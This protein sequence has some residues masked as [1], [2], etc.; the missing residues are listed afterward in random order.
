MSY[1]STPRPVRPWATALRTSLCGLALLCLAGPALGQDDDGSALDGPE[2]AFL[3]GLR[4]RGMADF[5]LLEIDRLAAAE[6][7]PAELVAALPFERALTLLSLARNPSAAGNARARLDEA[8]ALLE[9]FAQGNPNSPLAGDAQFL[10]AEILQQAAADLLESDDPVALPEETKTQAR[11]LLQDAERVYGDARTALEKTIRDIG[12]EQRDEAAAARRRAAQG[13]LIRARVEAARVIFRRAE[14]YAVGTPDRTR[15]LDEADAPLE[16]LRK[17]SRISI[18]SLPGRILQAQIRTARVPEEPAA[19]EALSGGAKDAAVQN[20]TVAATILK[21]VLDQQPPDGASNAVRDAVEA[22]RGTAQRL[23]LSVLN[24]PLKADYQTV[25]TQATQWLDGDRARLGTDSGAGVLFERGIAQ[26]RGAPE[27]EGRD[28]TRALR[29]ALADFQT[30]A[31]RSQAISGVAKEAAARVR[32]SLG[33]DREEPRTFVEAFD[34]A[35]DQLRQLKE[36][37]DAVKAA[38]TP[39]DK[40]AAQEDLDA[41]LAETSRLLNLANEL[42]DGNTDL[43]ELSRARYLLAWV[44]V[45][46]GRHYEAAVLAEFVARNFTP[47]AP[48]AESEQ[49]GPDQSGIPLEAAST[50]ALAWTQ[51]YTNRPAGTDGS[52]ELAQLGRIA[53]WISEKYPASD[54]ASAARI[55]LGRA[56]MSDGQMADAAEV[57]ATVPESDPAYADAQLK[58]G[59]ALVRRSREV[60]AM[61]VPPA[62][63]SVDA[64]RQQAMERLQTGVTKAEA[65]LSGE[66]KP[67]EQL[68]I[69]KTTLAQL[70]NGAGDFQAASDLLTGGKAKVLDAIA[71][72]DGAE[73]PP[74][75]VTS[76]KFAGLAYQ[77]LLRSQIGLKDIPAAQNTIQDIQRVSDGGNVGLFRSL[78]EEIQQELADMP[79]GPE[80]D[81]AR[82]N[83]VGFLDQIAGSDDQT[84]GSLM[85]VAETYG[86]L[87]E[88]LPAGSGE[89]SG[90]LNKAAT[91][92]RKVLKD[93]LPEGD[94]RAAAESGV[95][96]RLGELLAEAGKYQEG[97]EQVK[98]VLEEKPNALNGQIAAANL[99]ADWGE[100]DGD[101][102]TLAKALGGDGEAVW[103]WGKISQMLARQLATP[104]GDRFQADYNNARLR[105]PAV[106]A[107]LAETK[108]GDEKTAEYVKAE[109]ELLS[110]LTLTDP[111]KIA[112]DTRRDAEDLYQSLQEG[113]GVAV[114]K[115]LPSDPTAA[116][117]EDD[118]QLADGDGGP[119]TPGAPQA[120]EEEDAEEGPNV[121][122]LGV[123]VGVLVLITIGAIIAFRPKPRKRAARRSSGTPKDDHATHAKMKGHGV[124]RSSLPELAPIPAAVPDVVDEGPVG[125]DFPDFSALPQKKSSKPAAGTAPRT[126]S[127]SSSSGSSSSGSG[128]SGK[129]RRTSSSSAGSS[130][131]GSSSGSSSSGGSSSGKTRRSSSSG[132]SGSSSS[133]TSK[134]GKTVR[135][136]SSSSGSSSSDSSSS[137]SSSSGSSDTPRKR[138]P[139]P[140]SE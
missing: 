135:R 49:D 60:A 34:A 75:G 88:S 61:D 68:I 127:G 93:Y 39:A 117:G 66:A 104:E 85:W 125:T 43:G 95:K 98:A 130:T 92:L 89:A 122:L 133:A 123:G 73:R 45:Q 59:D 18:G 72:E 105:I 25:V 17:D 15:L 128:S 65:V 70:K 30:A 118:P 94:A 109:K 4:D 24:H 33:L 115:P 114:P 112:E 78:G 19:V 99:L 62:D 57:F 67:S 52:F 76:A 119:Q 40:A 139:K 20:L 14:T 2:R 56:L 63:E 113:R 81:E 64:L 132:S 8:A 11:Q 38:E 27:E 46:S 44:N 116:P 32:T 47:P 138:R 126:R 29:A 5:A 120:A 108:S 41:L 129:T 84:F 54:R 136:R 106:R 137:G 87:A 58:A 53:D 6:D 91:A 110:W 86:G 3:E 82:K 1:A 80:R 51:A 69:G 13:R 131:A 26:E 111:A 121:V 96:L 28:R 42:A 74:R 22:L 10:R 55:T 31:R 36:K 16:E 50:A 102:P 134:D 35:Q 37:Q 100:A 23:R 21:E 140:P 83:L 77:T 90:Y 79:P 9:S 7:T 71:V 97:Y 12:L 101:G 48:D 107:V 124:V 103:G